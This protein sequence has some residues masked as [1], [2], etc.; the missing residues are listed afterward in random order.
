[1]VLEISIIPFHAQY[2]QSFVDKIVFDNGLAEYLY[3]YSV[4]Q[5]GDKSSFRSLYRILSLRFSRNYY[6]SYNGSSEQLGRGT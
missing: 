6:K 1:M 4:G 5:T 2:L 3:Y